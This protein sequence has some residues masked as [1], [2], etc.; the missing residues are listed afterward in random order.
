MALDEIARGLERLRRRDELADLDVREAARVMQPGD[1]LRVGG[2]IEKAKRLDDVLE[3]DLGLVPGELSL[4]QK[5]QQLAA[6]APGRP[7]RH[8]GVDLRPH[9]APVAAL[10]G[11]LGGDAV[12]VDALGRGDRLIADE[13][14]DPFAEPA[15]DDLQRTE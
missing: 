7:L 1:L 15:G 10:R 8:A 3:R 14:L 13:V 12:I 11:G 4:D 9:G 2:R 5:A 6:L